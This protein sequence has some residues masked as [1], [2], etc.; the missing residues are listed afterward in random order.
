LGP[1]RNELSRRMLSKVQ[2]AGDCLMPTPLQYPLE[3]C[4]ALQEKWLQVLH[5]EPPRDDD[6]DDDDEEE[7]DAADREPFG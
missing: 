3:R 6:D 5:K 2:L 4:R 7:E 1:V